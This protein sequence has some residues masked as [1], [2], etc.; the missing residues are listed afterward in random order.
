V[1]QKENRRAQ[2]VG[3]EEEADASSSQ[4]WYGKKGMV[5]TDCGTI[6]MDK[7]AAQ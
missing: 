1:S 4:K 6:D 3:R 7:N 2:R 5:A